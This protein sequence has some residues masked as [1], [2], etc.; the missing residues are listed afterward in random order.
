MKEIIKISVSDTGEQDYKIGI[1]TNGNA[2]EITE[3][4]SIILTTMNESFN[5]QFREEFENDAFI[6]VLFDV[7]NDRIKRRC[8][9][10][11]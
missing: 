7:T 1:M 2:L 6:K 4:M 8:T 5:K 9:E 11:D 10:D 3:A